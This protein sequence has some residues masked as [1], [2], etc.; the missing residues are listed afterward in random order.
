MVLP[1]LQQGLRDFKHL[2]PATDQGRLCVDPKLNFKSR[3]GLLAKLNPAID[4]FESNRLAR[5][6]FSAQ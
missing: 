1:A 6:D 3:C 5:R 2:R 4:C